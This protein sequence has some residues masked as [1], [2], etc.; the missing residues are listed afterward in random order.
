MATTATILEEL[1][2]EIG[3]DSPLIRQKIESK[4]GD[5][6]LEI[7]SQN[8]GRFKALEKTQSISVL[9][10]VTRYKLNSDFNTAKDTFY[11]VD[12]LGEFVAR[13]HI[14][15]KSDA[16]SR[17]ADEGVVGPRICYVEFDS[18]TATRG[19]YLVLTQK[20]K[21]AVTYK[22]DYFRTPATSDTDVIKKH[23]AIKH[24][25]RGMSPEHFSNSQAEITIYVRMLS[26]IKES[27]DKWVTD[28]QVLPP[29]RFVAH[30]QFMHK[31]GGG[32]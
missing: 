31:I 9:V 7:L 10:D 15:S 4:I 21:T 6:V 27:P 25:V 1:I 17:L 5:V 2:A 19:W 24:G 16:F 11:E 18:A 28:A 8:E 30:N 26:G 23:A 29:A 12:S 13:C 3:K 20:P 32:G 14:V 22:F